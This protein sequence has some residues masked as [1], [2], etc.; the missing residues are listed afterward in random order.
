MMRYAFLLDREFYQYQASI[1]EWCRKYVGEGGWNQIILDD[2]ALWMIECTFGYT[3]I[4]FKNLADAD[5]FATA[6]NV[7][8]D[9]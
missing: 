1:I 5:S 3:K 6:W 4:Y 8:E 9:N 7:S 2:K